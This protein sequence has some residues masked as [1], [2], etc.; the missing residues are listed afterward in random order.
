M[1]SPELADGKTSSEQNSECSREKIEACKSFKQEQVALKNTIDASLLTLPEHAQDYLRE[2][3]SSAEHLSLAAHEVA[4]LLQQDA[5][6]LD[7]P[8]ML[9]VFLPAC[10][11]AAEII[12][13]KDELET[14]DSTIEGLRSRINSNL[15]GAD[16]VGQLT[17][18]MSQVVSHE[19]FPSAER[20]A[21]FTHLGQIKITLL[22]MEAVFDNP[23]KQAAFAQI[24]MSNSLDL[25]A[26]NLT[27]TFKPI[28]DEVDK[29][30]LFAEADKERLREIVTGSDVQDV[31]SEK[32][33]DG[34]YVNTEDNKREFRTGVS[35]Y[36]E[37]SG[38]QVIEVC[39]GDHIVTKDVTGWSGEDI[40]LMVE[41]MHYWHM[42]V[43]I[44]TTGFVENIYKIDSQCWIAAGLLIH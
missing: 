19:D 20:E 11:E 18:L 12:M 8:E 44:G 32:N 40:G 9:D 2:K 13:K 3:C 36:A 24:V 4:L 10:I 28:L 25:G 35:G 17:K 5:T 1:A 37:P 41:V 6:I 43:S 33:A 15:V 22:K 14:I 7:D 27:D 39:S 23:A 34:S 38:R 16:K 30:G 31:L 42:T 29:A 21:A 26:G